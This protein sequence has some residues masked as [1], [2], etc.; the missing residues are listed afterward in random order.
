MIIAQAESTFREFLAQHGKSPS[1]LLPEELLLFGFAFFESTRADDALAVTDESF[2]DALLF[3]WG[4]REALSPYY[5]ECYYFDLTRQF[6]SQQ[7][8]DDDEMFQLTCQLQYE[9]TPQLRAIQSGNCWCSNLVA[10]PDFK[11]S[12]FSHP[13][14]A[15]VKGQHPPK[16]EFYFT[17]V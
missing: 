14:L 15:A 7:G 16:V 10:L 5:A 13:A 2:G 8:Q 11:A 1:Q 4:T 3:Q 17:P 9:L 6:I 12:A